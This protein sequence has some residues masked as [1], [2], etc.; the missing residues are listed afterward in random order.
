[1]LQVEPAGQPLDRL[2]RQHRS[3]D[4][5]C[6]SVGFY[7]VR[8]TIPVRSVCACMSLI[9]I[10]ALPNTFVYIC[11]FFLIG[12][13]AY[14]ILP[15]SSSSDRLAVYSN[16]LMATLNARKSL[17]EKSTIHDTSMSLRDINPSGGGATAN[18]SPFSP[19][20]CLHLALTS[21]RS[22]VLTSEHRQSATSRP[23]SR[24]ASTPR[25][26]RGTTSTRRYVSAHALRLVVAHAFLPVGQVRQSGQA[27]G[28]RGCL[29]LFSPSCRSTLSWPRTRRHIEGPAIPRRPSCRPR[30]GRPDSVLS[31][32]P[33][34]RSPSLLLFS[35]CAARS[36]RRSDVLARTAPTPNPRY[37]V[38]AHTIALIPAAARAEISP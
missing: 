36:C 33:T 2:L 24:S 1:M 3:V 34:R 10:L 12:R 5:V 31:F 15:C 26:T 4:E 20:V 23:A 28:H 6:L 21:F 27:R 18:M 25:R 30:C 37:I 13:R 8:L 11:F 7:G 29:S 35:R 19:T 17:R 14:L 32:T 22:V 9:T 38:Q 16:S